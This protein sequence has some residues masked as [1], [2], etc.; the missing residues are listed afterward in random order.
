M[1]TTTTS[2]NTRRIHHSSR[3]CVATAASFAG[4]ASLRLAAALSLAAT[5]HHALDRAAHVAQVDETVVDDLPTSAA[6]TSPAPRHAYTDLLLGV[7]SRQTSIIDAPQTPTLVTTSNTQG[8]TTTSGPAAMLQAA[9]AAQVVAHLWQIGRALYTLAV[10]P[11]DATIVREV[12]EV[13]VLAQR[14]VSWAAV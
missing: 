13:P 5:L 11:L 7:C 9:A 3:L 2:R 4:P 8:A 6:A 1:C 10:P 14:V 12:C